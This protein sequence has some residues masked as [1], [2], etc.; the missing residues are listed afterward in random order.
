MG[1]QDFGHLLDTFLTSFTEQ[2]RNDLPVRL[3]QSLYSNLAIDVFR[4]SSVANRR[5][6]SS[7]Q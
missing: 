3:S 6:R 1:Y 4:S 2:S 7:N 5:R